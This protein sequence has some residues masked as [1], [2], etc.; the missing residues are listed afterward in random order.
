MN[1]KI[2]TMPHCDKC[3]EIKEYLS[4]MGIEEVDLGEAEG[5]A[6]IRKISFFNPYTANH[7]GK[8][9]E[10]IVDLANPRGAIN[11]LRVTLRSEIVLIMF[12]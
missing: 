2:Y 8:N 7:K 4:G 9:L 6:E 10:H 3:K 12:L 11:K 1:I 5:V